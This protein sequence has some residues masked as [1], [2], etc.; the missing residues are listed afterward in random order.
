MT[1]KARVIAASKARR[2]PP[3]DDCGKVVALEG[4]ACDLKPLAR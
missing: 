1:H 3:C 4:H 2:Y